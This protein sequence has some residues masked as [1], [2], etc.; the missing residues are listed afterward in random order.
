MYK[1]EML[2]KETMKGLVLIYN[3]ITKGKHVKRFVSKA[4]GVKRILASQAFERPITINK[5]Q[6]TAN[7]NSRA[8]ELIWAN[9]KLTNLEFSILPTF[10]HFCI[11]AGMPA[12]KRQASKFRMKKGF[13]YSFV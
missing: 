12:T 10:M 5:K 13:V 3:G 1:E 6:K 7:K 2:M 4:A 9:K 11:A 8:D